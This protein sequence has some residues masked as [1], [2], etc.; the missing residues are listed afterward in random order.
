MEK[1]SK[2]G[3]LEFSGLN[4][5]LGLSM[6]GFTSQQIKKLY[7]EKENKGWNAIFAMIYLSELIVWHADK[8]QKEAL[9]NGGV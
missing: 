3:D 9:K 6:D 1:S 4:N 8:R 2:C 5:Y 7:E